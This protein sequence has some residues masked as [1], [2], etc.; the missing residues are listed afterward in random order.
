MRFVGEIGVLGWLKIPETQAIESSLLNEWEIKFF[1]I[2]HNSIHRC[3]KPWARNSSSVRRNQLSIL[4]PEDPSGMV[5]IRSLTQ[6][7]ISWPTSM[8]ARSGIPARL[9][10]EWYLAVLQT[11]QLE[12]QDGSG[13]RTIM[14]PSTLLC[15][16]RCNAPCCSKP[17]RRACFQIQK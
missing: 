5:G 10:L 7:Q 9:A 13:S 1:P 6:C 16:R 17:R 11:A 14:L 3:S 4:T 8:A 15:W 12:S 2:F